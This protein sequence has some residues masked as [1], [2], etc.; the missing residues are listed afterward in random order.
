MELQHSKIYQNAY[1]TMSALINT[2]N[3]S[4]ISNGS[5][6]IFAMD[7]YAFCSSFRSCSKALWKSFWW[8]W[9]WLSH[10]S[11]YHQLLGNMSP[12]LSLSVLKNEEITKEE[13]SSKSGKYMYDGCSSVVIY[14]ETKKGFMLRTMWA[15]ALSW[16]KIQVLLTH[17]S[18][19]FW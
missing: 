6:T 13:I 16:C 19:H 4:V 2:C 8:F 14:L 11:W 10:W 3:T 7:C 9:Y 1:Q 12:S 5:V 15:G 18:L 17:K